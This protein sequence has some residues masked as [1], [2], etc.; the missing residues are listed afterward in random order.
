MEEADQL[1]M[2]TL[3]HLGL[4]IPDEKVFVLFL[5]ILTAMVRI[6]ERHICIQA[7]IGALGPESIVQGVL[8]CLYRSVCSMHPTNHFNGT[9]EQHSKKEKFIF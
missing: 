2:A 6:C 3:G 9:N 5:K 1:L 8:L 4:K 7:N